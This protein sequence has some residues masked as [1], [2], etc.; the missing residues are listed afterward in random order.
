MK[1]LFI[2]CSLVFFV[3]GCGKITVKPDFDDV[4]RKRREESGYLFGEKLSLTLDGKKELEK[5]ADPL[6]G[7]AKNALATYPITL[8]NFHVRIIQTDWIYP[9]KK[10]R[11]RMIVRLKNEIVD[12]TN[13]DIKVTMEEKDTKDQW[14][15]ST[16]PE[17]ISNGV[18]ND[19]IAHAKRIAH[20]QIESKVE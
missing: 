8:Q 6:W 2:A 3:T 18:K 11:Y 9:V 7:G 17:S 16:P 20:P 14:Q 13:I 4:E 5:A 15:P 1:T 10:S 12:P 19:I